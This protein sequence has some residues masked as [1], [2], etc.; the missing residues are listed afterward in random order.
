MFAPQTAQTGQMAQIPAR[1]GKGALCIL[2]F[3]AHQGERVGLQFDFAAPQ[4]AAGLYVKPYS[5]CAPRDVEIQCSDDGTS[6]QI[7]GLVSLMDDGVK[8]FLAGDTTLEEVLTVAVAGESV[9]A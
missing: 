6:W 8:K 7:T 9:S 2:T 4:T 3:I 5:D 1:A